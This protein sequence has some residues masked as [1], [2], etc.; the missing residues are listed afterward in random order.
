MG[1]A[2]CEKKML[3]I[4][5]PSRPTDF[6]RRMELRGSWLK[7][8]TS[9][10]TYRFFIGYT[11]DVVI[12]KSCLY[13]AEVYNDMIITDLFDSY[14]TLM[15]KYA[16][17]DGKIIF[18][19]TL[20]AINLKTNFSIKWNPVQKGIEYCQG[21]TYLVSSTAAKLIL[22]MTSREEFIKAEDVM[23]TGLLA[24]HAGVQR[25]HKPKHFTKAVNPETPIK[26][27]CGCDENEV[28]YLTSVYVHTQMDYQKFSK[29][30]ENFDCED[31]KYCLKII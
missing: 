22:P 4:A 24:E 2:D 1:D 27:D 26:T 8:I 5:I 31:S 30:L 28:P 29:Q 16:A 13:E 9:K 18:G 17:A 20:E 25:S 3:L 7:N 11:A 6:K 23:F 21:F 10:I 14:A 19:T 15:Y 12:K